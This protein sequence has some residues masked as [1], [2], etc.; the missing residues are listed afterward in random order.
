MRQGGFPGQEQ[1]IRRYARI[2]LEA[3]SGF[4]RT[5][6]RFFGLAF[7]AA[8]VAGGCGWFVGR[9]GGPVDAPP[10]AA[11][12]ALEAIALGP[13]A[14]LEACAPELLA[15]IEQGRATPILWR[16]FERL[17]VWGVARSAGATLRQR[18]TATLRVATPP[19]DVQA[20][21]QQ[22]DLR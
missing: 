18:L 6:R 15:E 13:L 7:A 9:G 3:E 4:K 14:R 8:A 10:R 2:G 11:P 16:G 12:N 1:M 22:L 17:A 21:V 5:R 20:V 19:P